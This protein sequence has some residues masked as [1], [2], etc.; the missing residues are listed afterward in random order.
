MA[1]IKPADEP[2]LSLR[3]A[4]IEQAVADYREWFHSPEDK[5]Q[6]NASTDWFDPAAHRKHAQDAANFLNGTWCDAL[7]GMDDS[8][9]TGDAILRRIREYDLADIKSGQKENKGMKVTLIQQTPNPVDVIVKAA[10]IC[11]DSHPSKKMGMVKF[12]YANGH[13]SPFEHVWF[14]FKVEGISRACSHQLVRHRLAS[15][16]QRSQRYCEENAFDYVV[17]DSIKKNPEAYD[18]YL[19]AIMAVNDAY[20]DMVHLDEIKRED[21]RFLLPNACTTEMVISMNLRELMHMANER[22]CVRA[23]WEIR[24]VVT[25][26]AALVDDSISWMLVPKCK[27]GYAICNTPCEGRTGYTLNRRNNV[28]KD[29]DEDE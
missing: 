8:T 12:L 28:K 25:R 5:L 4:I 27:T 13:H 15:F 7:L 24:E 19:K 2:F 20:C 18:K 26:M 1:N 9:V 23:Q 21:A 22:M 3:N 14:T 6:M 11:Y 17:P 16:T 29:E 10:S